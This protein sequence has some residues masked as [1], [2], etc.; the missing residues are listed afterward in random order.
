MTALAVVE[1]CSLLCSPDGPDT[2]FAWGVIGLAD[3]GRFVCIIA[4]LLAILAT[5]GAIRRCHTLGQHARFVSLALLVVVAV[6]TE[7]EHI[8][9][10]PSYRLI[11]N[12]AA[13]I[14]AACGLWSFRSET[15]TERGR[16]SHAAAA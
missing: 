1:T 15:P 9:D 14:A 7:T 11:L 2:P 13:A 8:G 16:G 5:P 10:Y 3:A 12:M 6:T 4:G